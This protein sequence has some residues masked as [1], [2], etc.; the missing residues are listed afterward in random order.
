MM[1]CEKFIIFTRGRT[2][3]TAIVDEIDLHNQA[4]C[5]QEPF[6]PL[7]GSKKLMVY[8]NKGEKIDFEGVLKDKGFLPFEF[9]L[10][11]W[12]S[13]RLF[14]KSIFWQDFRWHGI[15]G[16]LK[17]YL[18]EL[19]SG[20]RQ[21]QHEELK[22]FGFKL[23]IHHLNNWPSL[24]QIIKD[25]GYK[26]VYLE[27]KN[28]VKQVLS[29]M[30]AKQRGVYNRKNFVAP[31]E[32]YTLNLD[33]FEKLVK[34]ELFLVDEEKQKLKQE[35]LE[36]LIVSY[37]DFLFNREVFL[38]EVFEFIGVEFELPDASGYSIMIKDMKDIISNYDDLLVKVNEMGMGSFLEQ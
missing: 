33:D 21:K 6:I 2:G 9:W 29:G 32:A 4:S 7:S 38:R 34:Y 37:E 25:D 23:L 22:A 1:S 5:L 16:L 36:L 10:K 3:S 17:V 24:M 18:E 11:Q 35:G 8:V 27:R 20:E 19:R 30:V 15:S 13:M 12:H 28:V 26:V 31:D 14:G